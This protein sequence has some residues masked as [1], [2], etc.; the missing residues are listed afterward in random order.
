MTAP[1]EAADLTAA[2]P[3]ARIEVLLVGMNGDLRGKMIPL[4]AED[5]VWKNT[6]RL[7]SSTQSLDIWGDDNDDITRISL[8]LGD[9]DGICTPHKPSLTTLPRGLLS[10]AVATG[11]RVD[12]F[13]RRNRCRALRL[14]RLP[15]HRQRLRC[16]YRQPR[17]CRTSPP[18]RA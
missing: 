3:S 16:G 9:P 1:T 18:R 15:R 7:P 13:P 11:A 8:T 10:A 2:D 4:K 12:R 17:R 5:K 6:V 14:R